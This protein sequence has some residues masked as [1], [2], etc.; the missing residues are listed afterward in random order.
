MRTLMLLI[1]AFLQVL[2]LAKASS[3]PGEEFAIIFWL[4]IAT[5]ISLAL[6]ALL[7]VLEDII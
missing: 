2:I 4:A 5:G 3:T 7:D 1:L 6:L